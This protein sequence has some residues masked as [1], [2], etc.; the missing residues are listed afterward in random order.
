LHIADNGQGFDPTNCSGASEGHFG[1]LGLSE[2]VKRLDGSFE[3]IS[4]TGGGTRLEVKVP[5]RIEMDADTGAPPN[6][7]IST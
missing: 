4:V 3:I 5:I 7:E 6:L 1:L 2:R